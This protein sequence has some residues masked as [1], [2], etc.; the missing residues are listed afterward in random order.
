MT[1]KKKRKKLRVAFHKNRQK[2]ARHG[3]LT[4]AVHSEDT[5]SDQLATERLTGKGDLTRHRTIVG[6]EVDESGEVVRDVDESSCLTGTVVAFVGLNTLVRADDGRQFECS[7]RRV[8]RTMSRDERTAVV[9]GDRV[10]FQPAAAEQGVIE[11]IEPRRTTLSRTSQNRE[12]VLVANVDRVLIVV[13]AAEPAL[14]PNLVD[15]FLVSVGKGGAEPIICI[16][17]CDLV[18]R[19][20]LQ[21]VVGLYSGLGYDVVVTSATQGIGIDRVRS[22]LRNRQ[23]VVSGQSGVGKSSLL[24]AI[25]PRLELVTSGVSESSKKGRHTTR[26]ARLLELEFGGTV[27]DTPGIRQL[28][29]WDVQPEEV[30]GYFS[31]FRPFVRWCRFPD[32]TH[33]HESDCAL[34]NA[35]SA[36][37]ISESRYYSYLKIFHSEPD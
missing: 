18:R 8:V 3:D 24:N 11:R 2:R 31:E 16:N 5:D 28:E 34:K 14:K 22:L 12:H 37:L 21:P 35:V 32:C 30:E 27:V 10:L 9:T 19:I 6:V 13:S 26:T 7:V 15:R 29:L 36:D 1:G 25:D 4:R 33:S 17:K 20:E 23:T